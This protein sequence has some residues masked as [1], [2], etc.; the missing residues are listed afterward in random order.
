M[1][2]EEFYAILKLSSGEE[3]IS[4]VC[5]FLENDESLLILDNPISVE[6]IP[7]PGSRMPYLKVT[8]WLKV[9]KESTH[10]IKVKDIITMNELKDEFL[11]KMHCQYVKEQN[12]NN[13]EFQIT[14]EMGFVNTI[15][16]ARKS[17]ESLYNSEEASSNFE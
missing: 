16:N 9:F 5:A 13:K 15:Q 14:P 10:I 2:K 11:I 1:P 12:S 6:V 17:L 4:K 3:I 7:V 8:P